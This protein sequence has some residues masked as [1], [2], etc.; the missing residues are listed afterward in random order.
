MQ[1]KVGMCTRVES[2]NKYF[3]I[4]SLASTNLLKDIFIVGNPETK[5]I[6]N[7]KGDN[8]QRQKIGTERRENIG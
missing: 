5:L 3:V 6:L 2:D 8:E 4:I 7:R 1:L